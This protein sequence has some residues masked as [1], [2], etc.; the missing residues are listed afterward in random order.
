VQRNVPD[1]Y[2]ELLQQTDSLLLTADQVTRLQGARASY[3]ARIDSLWT[4][5]AGYLSNLPSVYDFDEASKHMD[6]VVDQAWEL[7]RLDV[8]TTYKE[9]L[10]PEQLAILPGWSHQL[11]YA[12]RPLHVRLFVQ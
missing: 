8:R 7:S 12:D 10:A 11:F 2:G 4:A 6:Q 9:I 1:P 5:L 3:R